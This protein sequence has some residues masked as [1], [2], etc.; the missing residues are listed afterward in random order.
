MKFEVGDSLPVGTICGEDSL[1]QG[2]LIADIKVSSMT[3]VPFCHLKTTSSKI[4]RRS[5]VNQTRSSPVW[6]LLIPIVNK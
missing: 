5:Q 3:G 1:L 4:V 2:V 6:W